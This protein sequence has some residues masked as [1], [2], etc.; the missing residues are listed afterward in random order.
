MHMQGCRIPRNRPHSLHCGWWQ[1]CKSNQHHPAQTQ[2]AFIA[3]DIPYVL[4]SETAPQLSALRSVEALQSVKIGQG[5]PVVPAVGLLGVHHGSKPR[6]KMADSASPAGVHRA[7]QVI[8]V[9]NAQVRDHELDLID[10]VYAS[11]VLCQQA[12]EYTEHDPASVC[13]L[14][15]LGPAKHPAGQACPFS[16]TFFEAECPAKHTSTCS[17][18][19][20]TMQ[21]Q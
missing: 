16:S 20:H 11:G 19:M 17:L 15:S 2:T 9:R 8:D 7:D 1:D 3:Q 14:V 18:L 10:E 4:Y 5:N 21:G 12:H 6:Y 13:D